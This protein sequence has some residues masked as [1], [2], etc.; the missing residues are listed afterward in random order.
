M[1]GGDVIPPPPELLAIEAKR[2]ACPRRRF[3][4]ACFSS[5]LGEFSARLSSTPKGMR[6]GVTL[7]SAIF[8]SSE[9]LLIK[10]TPGRNLGTSLGADLIGLI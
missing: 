4:C 2:S 5:K 8:P 7:L 6:E 3:F 1:D 10:R 9:D